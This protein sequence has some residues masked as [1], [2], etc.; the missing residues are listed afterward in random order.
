MPLGARISA[1]RPWGQLPTGEGP[2]CL[3]RQNALGFRAFWAP[4]LC[5][6][7]E[8]ELTD[9][10]C[11]HLIG[12]PAHLCLPPPLPKEAALPFAIWSLIPG[13]SGVCSVQL[14]RSRTPTPL[15]W[16]MYPRH[17]LLQHLSWIQSRGCSAPYSTSQASFIGCH[18]PGTG[19][20]KG[21]ASGSITSQ[22]TMT[23]TTT[24][25]STSSA[26]CEPPASS[27]SSAPSCFCWVACASAPAG[28]TAARTTSSSAPASSSWL[29]A[30]VTSLVSSST[31]PATQATRV[32]SG[33]KTK[34]T[35]TTMAGLFTLELC[36]SLWLRPWASWL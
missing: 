13:L 4:F 16:R 15:L 26:S 9:R 32:T 17:Y 1:L 35:I 12:D 21:T 19:S 3:Q 29:Q 20:I 31:F 34:R 8:L 23:T 14:L 7:A 10:A 18:L 5:P 11:S 36:L 25:R 33:M 30:S 27:P 28:S 24:A 22:R 2:G 6:A